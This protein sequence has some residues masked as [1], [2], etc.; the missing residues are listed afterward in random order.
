VELLTDRE[1]FEHC[2]R[3]AAGF[4]SSYQ[5]ND[6]LEPLIRFCGHPRMAGQA[7]EGLSMLRQWPSIV[8]RIRR[9]IGGSS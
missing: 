7:G 8:E 3:G 6:L 4:V 5:W 2:Q 1:R 9:R